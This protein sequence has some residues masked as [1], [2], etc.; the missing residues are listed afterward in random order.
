VRNWS[1]IDF[2]PHSCDTHHIVPGEVLS[3][4]WQF[5]TTLSA[6]VF[7]IQFCHRKHTKY[8]T[9]QAAIITFLHNLITHHWGADEDWCFDGCPIYLSIYIYLPPYI[10]TWRRRFC[11]AFCVCTSLSG[12]GF[13]FCVCHTRFLLLP[14]PLPLL[15]SLLP[16][17]LHPLTSGG[18]APRRSNL[19]W[20]GLLMASQYLALALFQYN[21]CL[22]ALID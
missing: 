8:S 4:K 11:Q 13:G 19:Y 14:W 15:L 17:P 12:I 3:L 5:N 10:V 21:L 6:G 22:I 1:E 2:I 18:S 16:F 9:K 7:V 20:Q